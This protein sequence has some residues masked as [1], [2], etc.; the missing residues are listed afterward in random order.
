MQR[1]ALAASLPENACG[2]LNDLTQRWAV[3]MLCPSPSKIWF[4]GLTWPRKSW[5][6]QAPN[7]T[8]KTHPSRF[9][10]HLRLWSLTHI[11]RW[12][13]PRLPVP[14]GC[15]KPFHCLPCILFRTA[16]CVSPWS[17]LFRDEHLSIEIGQPQILVKKLIESIKAA[18][19]CFE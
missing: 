17:N 10:P 7:L 11:W 6:P 15:A 19:G 5:L 3:Q 14:S 9:R 12:T 2:A 18:F 1:T 4:I 16:R 8:C 13:P